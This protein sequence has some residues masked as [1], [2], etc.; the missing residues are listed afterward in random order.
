MYKLVIYY[1]ASLLSLS[2]ILSFFGILSYNALDIILNSFYLMTICYF[3][4]EI[5][6]KIWKTKTNPESSVITALILSLIV[7]PLPFLANILNYTFIAIFAMGSKYLI[8]YH[9]KHIFNPA[10]VSVVLS[11]IFLNEVASW[12]VGNIYLAPIVILFGL[13]LLKKIGRRSMV[14]TFLFSYL[15]LALFMNIGRIDSL[16]ALLDSV[17]SLLFYSPILFFTFV[18]FVEPQTSPKT[19]WSR[20]SYA[21][22]TAV[23]I[24]LYQNNLNISYTLELSLL[25]GNLFA[26]VISRDLRSNM[27]LKKKEEI[28]PGIFAFSFKSKRKFNFSPG[29]FL[30]WTLYHKDA[31]SRGMRRYFT[32][33]SSPTEESILLTTKIAKDASKSSTWKQELAT[34]DP[35]DAIIA[36]GPEG[37]FVLA[38]D[39]NKK[40]AFIAGGIGITPFRSMAKFLIDKKTSRDVVLVYSANSEREF[41]FKDIFK[42]ASFRTIYTVTDEKAILDGWSG[43]RGFVDAKMIEKNIP[44]WKE[45]VFYVSGPEPMVEALEKALLEFGI[46]KENL[47]TDYFPGY[48]EL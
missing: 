16:N 25:S 45:R 41:V 13:V 35:G 21:I 15:S 11:A 27:I 19:F 36:T 12:W 44:D 3:S 37:D 14:F 30:E 4:N 28:A 32:I 2:I 29:Q 26:F 22:L 9:G 17:S 40:L 38:A 31:D 8:T 39:E 46:A 5:F 23:A 24:V 7:G 18:M 10:A 6:S 48:E 42:E 34:L 1:L 33:A 47:K 20:I 43:E